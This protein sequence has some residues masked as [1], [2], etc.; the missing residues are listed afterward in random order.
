MQKRLSKNL[1]TVNKKINIGLSKKMKKTLLLSTLLLTF[2]TGCFSFQSINPFSKEK[3]KLEKKEIVIPSNAPAWLHENKVKNHI[4]SIGLSVTKDEKGSLDK[5]EFVFHRQKALISASQNLTKKIYL[6]TLT[7]YKNYLEKLD[8]PNIYDK[9]IKKFAEHIALKSL[10]HSDI[11]N[12]WLSNEN[13]LFV[14]ITVD[15]EIVA[16]QIQNSSKLLFDVNKSLYSHFLSNRAKKDI[17]KE[18]EN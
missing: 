11:S 4:S 17:I 5:E 10:T 8:S 3:E 6:K 1:V 9:D 15:S 18:L 14:Q 12:H 2:F 16:T 13:K 7:L